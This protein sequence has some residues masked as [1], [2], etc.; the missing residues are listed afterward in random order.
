MLN[1]AADL[2]KMDMVVRRGRKLASRERLLSLH[3]AIVIRK[4]ETHPHSN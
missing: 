1:D 3:R 4:L 2:S